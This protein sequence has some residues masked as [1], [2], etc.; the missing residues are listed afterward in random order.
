MSLNFPHKTDERGPHDCFAVCFPAIVKE[1]HPLIDLEKENF[2]LRKDD[3]PVIQVKEEV[4][5]P[6]NDFRR[7]SHPKFKNIT[8]STA[9]EEVKLLKIGDYIIRPS[10]EGTE[11]L[12]ITWHFYKNVISHIKLKMEQKSNFPFIQI[13]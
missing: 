5:R 9:V 8:L 13:S 6:R 11:Y 1:I 3:R 12:T 7:I 4:I 10:T 2:D